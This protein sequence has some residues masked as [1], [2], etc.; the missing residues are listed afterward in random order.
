MQSMLGS[1]D[2]AMMEVRLQQLPPFQARVSPLDG[3][4]TQLI[5]LSWLR[6]D[7]LVKGVN[8]LFQDQKGIKDC[9]GVDE[10]D[11][12]QWQSLVH[13][14]DEQG[15]NSFIVPFDFARALIVDARALNRRTR[16]KLPIAYSIWRPMTESGLRQQKNTGGAEPRYVM[17]KLPQVIADPL[18]IDEETLRLAREEG[19]AI[20]QC[21]EFA[22]WLY[23]P[24]EKIE[25]YISRYWSAQTAAE[26]HK[27]GGRKGLQQALDTLVDEALQ[28]LIDEK[29][30]TLYAT[31]LL[32]QAAIFQQAERDK[33]ATLARAVATLL[34]AT[35]QLPIIEQ[36]FPRAL[37]RISIEQGPLRLMME[38]LRGNSAVPFF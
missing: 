19:A 36:A 8:V 7:G 13:D 6:P 30:C 27:R 11:A 1:E 15:F 38:S 14:L 24:V 9:Y 5:M 34:R 28:E 37:L 18:P 29:W 26:S 16:T 12:E 32:R 4:G 10:M 23:D 17:K 2:A 31:R 25:P 35:D 22:S 21:H 20:Y 33:D 3:S